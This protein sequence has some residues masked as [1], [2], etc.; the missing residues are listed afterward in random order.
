MSETKIYPKGIIC[1][2][3]HEKQLEFV[4]GAVVITIDEFNE[5][6]KQ[7]QHLLSDYQGKKQLKL[8]LLKGSKGVDLSVDTY[9]KGESVAPPSSLGG[10]L[11]F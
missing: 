8:Q 4:L 9:K 6:V 10:G 2:P 7:N 5:W 3:K 1:F 11:Q